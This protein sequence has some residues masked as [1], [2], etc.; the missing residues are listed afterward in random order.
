MASVTYTKAYGRNA[1]NA[2]LLASAIATG[3]GEW[4]NIHGFQPCTVEITGITNATVVLS[5]SCQPTKPA[6]SFHGFELREVTTDGAV[7]VIDPV[8]WVKA[9][10]TVYTSGTISA[11]LLGYKGDNQ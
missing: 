3:N 7:K 4:I 11:Y 9:R 8:E 2:T 10:V 1:I 6:N 5:G